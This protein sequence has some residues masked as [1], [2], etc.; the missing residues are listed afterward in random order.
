MIDLYEPLAAQPDPLAL[1]PF[2]IEN[3]LT[4]EGYDLAARSVSEGIRAHLAT[5]TE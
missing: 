4:A 1:Y 2:R 3:H 5:V